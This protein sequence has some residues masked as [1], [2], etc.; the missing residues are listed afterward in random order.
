VQTPVF[1]QLFQLSFYRL[2]PLIGCIIAGDVQAYTYLTNSPT[3]IPDAW[4][5]KGMM[6]PAGC[7]SED[8]C[9]LSPGAMA[10]HVA[11]VQAGCGAA[12]LC[13]VRGCARGGTMRP[14]PREDA[15]RHRARHLPGRRRVPAADPALTMW[16][17]S[18]PPQEHAP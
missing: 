11:E 14:Q 8:V 9:L 18:A 6:V 13:A 1:K 12:K 16:I 15:V 17:C 3:N 10:L 4:A 5:L 7:R 2:V